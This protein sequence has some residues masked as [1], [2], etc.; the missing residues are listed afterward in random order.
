MDPFTMALIAGA[1]GNMIKAGGEAF[2]AFGTAQDLKLTD[3]QK[4]RMGDLERRAAQDALGLTAAE[5]ERFRAEAMSPVQTAEREAIARQAQQQQIADIGQAETFRGQQALKDTAQAAR[6]QIEQALAQR[7]AQVAIQQQE[8]LDRLRQ[9]ELQ[10]KALERQA[11]M[12]LITRSGETM[13]KVGGLKAQKAMM[14][15][16]LQKQKDQLTG[17]AKIT[18]DGAAKMLGISGTLGQ[19][20]GTQ[21]IQGLS[22]PALGMNGVDAV[23]GMS[24]E[25]LQKL[26]ALQQYILGSY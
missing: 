26:I 11:A 24:Y 18:V 19:Q 10:R 6:A 17:A 8:E 20:T 23:E 1:Y 15:E 21:A 2:G 16:S 4:R 3:E 12:T 25:D 22:H 14:D 7:N 9:Q 13:E 5:R